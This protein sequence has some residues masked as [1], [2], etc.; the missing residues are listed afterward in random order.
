MRICYLHCEPIYIMRLFFCFITAISVYSDIHAQTLFMPRNIQKSYLKG[1][2]SVDG[3][4]GKN[5]WQN[6]A[7]YNITVTAMPPDRYI[8][9]S[10]TINYINNSP[11]TLRNATI[12]LFVNIHKPGAPRAMDVSSDYL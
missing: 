8:K 12:K 2:R 4:P 7:R 3:R 1:T 11:D 10:E 9:G 5:Y 6:H